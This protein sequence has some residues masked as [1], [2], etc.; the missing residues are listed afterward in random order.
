MGYLS[1]TVSEI[2]DGLAPI[3]LPIISLNEVI[4]KE[5]EI[6]IRR[7]RNKIKQTYY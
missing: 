2:C 3:I 6:L 5:K 7:W 4:R 1:E